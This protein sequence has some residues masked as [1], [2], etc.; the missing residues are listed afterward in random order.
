MAQEI[1]A[2]FWVGHPNLLRQRG[3]DLGATPCGPRQLERNWRFDNGQREMQ[4]SGSVL[5]LRQDDR[6]RLT[7]KAPGPTPEIRQEIEVELIGF[8]QAMTLLA[9][10][11][12]RPF[13]I[14]EKMRE[15]LQLGQTQIMLDELPYGFFVEIE[16]PSLS[17]VQRVSQA[18]GLDWPKRVGAS[19][20]ALFEAVRQAASL[21]A[22]D[23]TFDAL[24]DFDTTSLGALIGVQDGLLTDPGPPERDEEG[25]WMPP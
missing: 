16:G 1:E 15:T 21:T 5:R 7:F 19:Y 17:E 10:L 3:L 24:A 18:L 12:Y 13:F 11:G 6:L 9:G 8:E 14:Y 2:K 22:S 25:Q 20:L 4:A 23:A